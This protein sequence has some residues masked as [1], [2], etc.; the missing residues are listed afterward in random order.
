MLKNDV[1]R[2]FVPIRLLEPAV[3][4]RE[5]PSL[6]LPGNLCVLSDVVEGGIGFL[7]L[8]PVLPKHKTHLFDNK[9]VF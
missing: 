4:L 8:D 5:Q 9:K 7:I 6:F 3:R 1:S 2:D